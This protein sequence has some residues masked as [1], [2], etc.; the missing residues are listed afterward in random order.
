MLL[1]NTVLGNIKIIDDF[2]I[3]DNFVK[4]N[5]ILQDFTLLKTVMQ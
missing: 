2:G 5:N 3:T 4:C 1:T